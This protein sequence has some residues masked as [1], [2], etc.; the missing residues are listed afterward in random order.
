MA[1]KDGFETAPQGNGSKVIERL[2]RFIFVLPGGC[3]LWTGTINRG[4]Y[5]MFWTGRVMTN[6][7]IVSWHVHKKIPIGAG[8]ELDHLCRNRAC[9]NPD[10]LEPVTSRENCLRGTS[11]AAQNAR[12]THCV[13]GHELTESNTYGSHKGRNCVACNLDRNRRRPMKRDGYP[14]CECRKC[15]ARWTAYRPH[16]STR[17]I[18]CRA[19]SRHIKTLKEITA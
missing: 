12:K 10:H 8:L 13:R 4:G 14:R 1:G 6:A 2:L 19:T 3:W 15:G 16:P 17:C 11:F 7:H 5:G 9:V 18:N